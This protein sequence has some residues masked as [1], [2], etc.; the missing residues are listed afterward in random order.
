MIV[1]MN[2]LVSIITP[3]YNH[4]KFIAECIESVLSQTY[5]HW[6]MIIID[7]ASTDKTPYIIEEYAKKD[8]RIIFIRHQKNWGIYRLADTY[9]QAL[10]LSKGDYIAILEGDDFWPK[11]KLSKQIR[12]FNDKEV[13]LSYGKAIIVSYDKKFISYDAFS[14]NS[15]YKQYF[16][17][18]KNEVFK[19]L[20]EKCFITSVTV[21]IRKNVLLEKKGFQQL[22]GIPTVDYPTW[23]TLSLE[24]KFFGSSDLLGYHRANESSQSLTKIIELSKKGE[25]VAIFFYSK[26][27]QKD[28]TIFKKIKESWL[29]ERIFG[30]WINGRNLYFN[31]KNKKEA[32]DSFFKGIKEGKIWY[33]NIRSLKTKILCFI[34]LICILLNINLEKIIKLLKGEKITFIE[35]LK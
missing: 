4:E 26:Y 30:Y 17:N 7:D 31:V 27:V 18:S 24:G 2:P 12:C 19:K 34:G 3:T 6:E 20:L 33:L 35:G 28:R 5:P 13:V 14:T 1:C 11:D 25:D 29:G 15:K 22:L 32:M 23:L 16:N 10:E 8:N 9:N 21:V